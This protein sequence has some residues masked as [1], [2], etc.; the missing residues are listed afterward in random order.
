M[1]ERDKPAR[2]PLGGCGRLLL[3]AAVAV[4]GFGTLGVGAAG[5]A[6]R[7]VAVTSND[8]TPADVTIGVGD[9]VTWS[10]TQGNHNVVFED[11]LFTE[12]PTV[13]GP[14]WT[15]LRAFTTAGTFPYFCALHDTVG[16]TG[17]VRVVAGVPLPPPG[18]PPPTP[19]PAPPP[20]GELP[21]LKVT[22]KV[23]DPTPRAGRRIRLF[24][25]VRPQQN[26][27]TVQIQRR[28]R[29]GKFTTVATARLSGDGAA[30]SAYS[31]RLRVGRDS[32]FRARV[33]GDA[34][35]AASVSAT[36]RVDVRNPA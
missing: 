34:A 26:G 2:G 20:G 17:I 1:D 35:H 36:K 33:P 18:F 6:D 5:A 9:T 10:N 8:F 22:L 12:P 27:R 24:G 7:P 11:G 4:L 13:L 29:T 31:R 23:S 16:M 15:R 30:Q 21:G 14:P 32:A 19:G 3:A 25:A 28:S